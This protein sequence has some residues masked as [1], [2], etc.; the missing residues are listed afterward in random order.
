MFPAASTTGLATGCRLSASRVAIP[1]GRALLC[2][3]P[4]TIWTLLRPVL[5][6]TT[7]SNKVGVVSTGRV[8]LTPNMILQVSNAWASTPA[9]GNV[10][11]PPRTPAC[12]VTE[13]SVIG[14]IIVAVY[15]TY[16]VFIRNR[17]L[18]TAVEIIPWRVRQE[19]RFLQVRSQVA[20]PWRVPQSDRGALRHLV[21]ANASRL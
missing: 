13:C 3:S 2:R 21:S 7:P 5:S 1:K 9:Q 17:Q 10:I 15:N 11:C 12:G 16:R 20:A 14:F 6:G 8:G 19:Q 18:L 4:W